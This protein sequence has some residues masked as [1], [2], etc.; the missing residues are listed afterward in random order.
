M[1]QPDA[2]A[3][4]DKQPEVTESVDDLQTGFQTSPMET[5]PVNTLDDLFLGEKV[6][7]IL[8]AAADTSSYKTIEPFKQ[9]DQP[10]PSDKGSHDDQEGMNV[11]NNTHQ[12]YVSFEFGFLITC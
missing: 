2:D 12:K 5:L 4:E 6:H 1:S 10:N 3:K 7:D 9:N 8:Q 11:A